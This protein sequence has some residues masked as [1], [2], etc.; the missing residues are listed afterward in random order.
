M[1]KQRICDN[2]GI[3]RSWLDM[4]LAGKG[5]PSAKLARLL[6]EETGVSAEAWIFPD[7]HKN[8]YLDESKKIVSNG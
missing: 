8:P 6:E 1:D 5:R 7:R 4:I 2:L 3:T